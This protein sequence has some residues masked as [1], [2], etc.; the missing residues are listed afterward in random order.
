M[1][2]IATS[3]DLQVKEITPREMAPPEM[4]PDREVWERQPGE[5]GLE[6]E[7]FSI[8][9]DLSPEKRSVR[10]AYREMNNMDPDEPITPGYEANWYKWSNWWSWR[11]RVNAYDRWV[12]KRIEEGLIQRRIQARAETAELG[13]VLKMQA[14]EAAKAM[15]AVIY[16]ENE[17]GERI[18]KSALSPNEIARLAQIGADLESTAL[19]GSEG[20]GPAV[21]VQ[22][23]IQNLRERAKSIL[24]EQEDVVSITQELMDDG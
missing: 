15:Q 14:Y 12:N 19:G 23:N 9:R 5:S 10:A 3:D 24:Q 7:A 8:Y 20:E 22:V 13:R 2:S 16:T 11:D 21:A 18:P 4:A 17:K 6:Y 1:A